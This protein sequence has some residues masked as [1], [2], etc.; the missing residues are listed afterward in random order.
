MAEEE[1]TSEEVKKEE[2]KPDAADS[3]K[4]DAE[5]STKGEI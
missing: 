3:G 2:E 5:Y 4:E 1:T